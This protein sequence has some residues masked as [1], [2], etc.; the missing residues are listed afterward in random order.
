MFQSSTVENKKYGQNLLPHPQIRR[1]KASLMIHRIKLKPKRHKNTYTVR[2]FCMFL[3]KSFMST[4]LAAT[5]FSL[6]YF[7]G[8]TIVDKPSSVDAV[9]PPEIKKVNQINDIQSSKARL[10]FVAN[11]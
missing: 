1:K 5:L 10:P 3:K 6:L 2:V 9:P 11:N 7:I 4:R 8:C